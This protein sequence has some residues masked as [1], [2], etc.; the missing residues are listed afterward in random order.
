MGPPVPAEAGD[1]VPLDFAAQCEALLILFLRG[2]GCSNPAPSSA[3]SANHRFLSSRQA[4][5]CAGPYQRLQGRRSGGHRYLAS[6]G[7]R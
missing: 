1:A 7:A 4:I 5:K 6:Q 3:E 2:T